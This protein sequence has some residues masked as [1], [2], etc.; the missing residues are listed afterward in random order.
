MNNRTEGDFITKENLLRFD[1]KRLVYFL[2]FVV[3]FALTEIGRE[4]YRPYIYE[5]G[6]SDFGAADTVGNFF[7]TITQVYFMLFLLNP[8]YKNG[9]WFFLFFVIGYSIYEIAQ[10]FME[11][12]YF[13]WK[14]ILA[15]ILAGGIALLLYQQIFRRRADE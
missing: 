8:T 12:S 9:L 13:D 10:L 5:N 2:I 7:G 4:V 1:K 6:I 15:T 11:G 3:A 14:D